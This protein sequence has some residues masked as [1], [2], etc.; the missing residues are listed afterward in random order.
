MKV[1]YLTGVPASGKTT[2]LEHISKSYSA[3]FECIM[4]GSLL[5][6][7]LKEQNL[8]M[9]NLRE[10]SSQVITQ[11]AVRTADRRLRERIDSA[12]KHIILESHVITSEKYGYRA[13]PFLPDQLK[14]F[15]IAHLITLY[16]SASEIVQRVD[17]NADGRPRQSRDDIAFMQSL[18]GSVATQYAFQLG[19]PAYFLN[20]GKCIEQVCS[21]FFDLIDYQAS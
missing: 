10:L 6:D 11:E 14:S 5:L 3:D 13:I 17:R 20:T 7:V 8:S 16:A 18:Q 4:Y 1:I 21:S 15:N 2:L 9:K 19:I 12:H